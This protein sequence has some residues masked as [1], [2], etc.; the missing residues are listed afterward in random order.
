MNSGFAGPEEGPEV[1]LDP[2][3]NKGLGPGPDLNFMGLNT[4]P[5][6]V[7]THE[8]DFMSDGCVVYR[9]PDDRDAAN[10][11]LSKAEVVLTAKKAARAAEA[12][13]A[14]AAEAD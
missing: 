13:A 14:K 6:A 12:A 1:G 7:P 10:Q 11:M 3:K 4:G 9:Q 8:S 5:N 2:D